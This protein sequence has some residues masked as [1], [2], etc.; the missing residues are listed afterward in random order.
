MVSDPGQD[1]SGNGHGPIEKKKGGKQARPRAAYQA[2]SSDFG[3]VPRMQP[4]PL[5]EAIRMLP[6]RYRFV[7]TKPG[8][9]PFLA[10]LGLAEWKIV[11]FQLLVYSVVAALL[12]SLRTLL[13]PTPTML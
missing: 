2:W 3:F 8:F 4:L 12:T 9:E 7:L 1:H 6:R 5:P 13:Y 11:W 10:E